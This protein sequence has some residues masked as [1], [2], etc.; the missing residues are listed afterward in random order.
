MSNIILRGEPLFVFRVYECLAVLI[1]LRSFSIHLKEMPI[2]PGR[3]QKSKPA[4]RRAAN[5]S[6]GLTFAEGSISVMACTTSSVVKKW[7]ASAGAWAGLYICCKAA[8]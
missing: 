5:T 3:L 4:A 1:S 7:V 2:E 6:A 8:T